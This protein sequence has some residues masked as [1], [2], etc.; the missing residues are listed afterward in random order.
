MIFQR[1]VLWKKFCPIFLAIFL[2]N[3]EKRREREEVPTPSIPPVLAL[4]VPDEGYLTLS[5]PD[6]GY[7][8][9]SIPDEGYSRNA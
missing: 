5:V 8:A 9:L 2:Y 3:S 4:S 1:R 7:L 6:E